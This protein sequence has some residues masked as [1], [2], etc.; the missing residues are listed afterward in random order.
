MSFAR[1][2]AATDLILAN[3]YNVPKGFLN[4]SKS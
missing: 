4:L 3:D 1:Q 2:L